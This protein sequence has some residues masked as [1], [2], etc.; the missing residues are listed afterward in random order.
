VL[1]TCFNCPFDVIKSRVQADANL[2]QSAP[3]GVVQRLLEI[4]RLEG[5]RALWKGFNAKA[6]KMGLGGSVG[7]AAFEVTASLLAPPV[8][9]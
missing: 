3:Q 9:R 1:A 5:T 2:S 8:E 7:M 4:Q 6:F